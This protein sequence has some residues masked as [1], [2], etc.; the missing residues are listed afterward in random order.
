MKLHELWNKKF[1]QI[2]SQNEIDIGRTNLIELDIPM[3]GPLIASKLY[4]VLLKYLEFVDHEIKQLGEAGIILQSMS[5]WASPILVVPKKQGHMETINLQGSNNGKFNLQLCINYRKLNSHIQT[6]H[7]IKASGSLGKVITNYPLLT[8]ASILV[9]F[10]GCKYFSTINL[11]S[12]YYYIR[13]SKEVAEKT[14]FITDKGKWI[15]HSLPLG[16]NIGPSTLSYVIGKVHTQCLEF[17]LNYHDD[18]MVFSKMWESHL[19]HLKE[20]FK[21]LQDVDLKIKCSKCEFFKSK[22][23]YLGYL[24]GTN[25]VQPLPEKVVTIKALEPPKNIEELWHFLG[26]ARFYRKFIPSFAN[27][28]AALNTML[29]KGAVFKWTEQCNNA[30]NL[31]KSDF[32]KM[33]RL[34]FPNPN[35]PFKLFMDMSK[36]SYSKYIAS[37]GGIWWTKGGA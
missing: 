2:I 14:A 9:H 5:D 27:V 15:F 4:T 26:L 30:F 32:V 22:V 23:H 10:N 34:L 12:G 6:A 13:L 20:V 1:P 37:R 28:T 11:R 16:I 33:P 25:C 7:Q 3:E 21:W 24:V 8:I 18:I 17:T 29:W 36:H 35:K 31:L 19:R